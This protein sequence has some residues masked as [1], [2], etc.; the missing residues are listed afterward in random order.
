MKRNSAVKFALSL[1]AFA[2]LVSSGVANAQSC[3]TWASNIV[4]QFAAS[5]R[6][7]LG[8]RFATDRSDGAYVSYSASVGYPLTYV[9]A[10]RSGFAYIPPSLQGGS[11]QFFSDR[12]YEFNGNEF[13][14]SPTATDNLG[15]TIWLGTGGAYSPQT[16]YSIQPG[17]VTFTLYSWGNATATFVP[18]RCDG[19]I[20]GLTGNTGLLLSLFDLPAPPHSRL[21][22]WPRKDQPY[23][24]FAEPQEAQRLRWAFACLARTN[25]RGLLEPK[26]LGQAA[27]QFPPAER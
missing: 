22:C 1:V 13:P 17:D 3:S 4:T 19:M 14:F 8:A 24:I 27:V 15:M 23:W 26:G 20:Y 25:P 21:G 2:G 10:H 7:S 18:E 6:P 9:P 12:L 11:P 5:P 16:G